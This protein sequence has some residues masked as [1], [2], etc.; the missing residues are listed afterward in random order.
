MIRVGRWQ[1]TLQHIYEAED[2][3]VD[4]VITDAPYSERTHTGQR[5]GT[6]T[7]TTITY[8][9]IT[10]D[11]VEDF[12]AAWVP[13]VTQWFVV[14]GDHI[15]QAWWAAA[16]QD[17]GLYVFAP[18]AWVRTVWT[19]RKDASGPASGVEYITVARPRRVVKRKASRPP[20]YQEAPVRSSRGVT[21]E[22]PLALMRRIVEDYT[23]P[24]DLVVDPFSGRGTTGVACVERGRRFEG[25]EVSASTA[26]AAQRRIAEAQAQHNL[27]DVPA[28]PAA[29]PLALFDKATL[30]S[31]RG[32]RTAPV[33]EA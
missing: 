2:P 12:V 15:T 22:K 7:S 23:Q 27:F 13:V 19:P 29:P 6:S 21:G 11:D 30:R 26:R 17:A 25:S 33:L 24:G 3:C 10:R 5:S 1:D 16:F 32:K 28:R 4:S 20:W 14:F 8:N 31:T 18:V 9:S